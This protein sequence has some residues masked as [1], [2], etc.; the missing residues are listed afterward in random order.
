MRFDLPVMVAAA[1]A[2]LP[3]AFTGLAIAR[4]E[5]ALFV[6]YYAAYVTYVV[7]TAAEHARLTSFSTAMRLLVVPLTLVTL[8]VTSLGE[9]RVHR[10]AASG[11]AGAG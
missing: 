8:A 2:L 7:L 5:G 6:A 10:R 3:I 9:V 1:L 4:W 11:I